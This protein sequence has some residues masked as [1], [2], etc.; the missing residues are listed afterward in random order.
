MFSKINAKQVCDLTAKA[1][2]SLEPRGCT[3]GINLFALGTVKKSHKTFFEVEK[4][5]NTPVG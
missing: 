2:S 5:D 4:I 3:G 1:S